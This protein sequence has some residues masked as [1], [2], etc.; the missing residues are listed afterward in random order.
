MAGNP[1][2]KKSQAWS[3]LFSEPM[4]QLVQRYTA[5]VGFDRRLARADIAGSLAHARMLAAQK[6]ISAQDLADIERGLKQIGY[7]D[8]VSLECGVQGDP[9]VE[10]PKSF[11]FIKKQWD[12]ATP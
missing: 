9:D 11:A 1:L 2:D 3:A 12:E 7:Q 6:I 10:I 5:S 8:F 4:D